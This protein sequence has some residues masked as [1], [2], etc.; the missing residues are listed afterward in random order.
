MS[1]R[2]SDGMPE[3]TAVLDRA[4][5]R[6]TLRYR[7]GS[8]RMPVDRVFTL[9]GIGTVVTGTVW[10]GTVAVGDTVAVEPGDLRARARS[11]HVHD[12][13]RE[14]ASAG[15]R[16]AVALP[17]ISR[18]HI[19]R[20]SWLVTP[21]SVTDTY[22]VECDLRVTGASS[23]DLDHGGLVTVHHGTAHVPARVLTADGESIR[24]GE[25]G[26][27]QLRLRSA[28]FAVAGDRIIV[29]LTA[30]PATVA[31]G[32]ILNPTARRT[33]QEPEAAAP[34]A[35][36][37][38]DRTGSEDELHRRIAE[39]PLAPPNL[40]AE[41][42]PLIAGLV[43]RGLAVRASRD[44]AFDAGAFWD[45]ADAVLELAADAPG[46]T[47][48]E[49]RDRLGCSRRHAQAIVEGLD[50]AGFTRRVGE[51]RVLRRRGRHQLDSR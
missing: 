4:V 40:T 31:G 35:R 20:G 29:R 37:S 28:L 41:D 9:R 45:A 18:D 42:D 19:G 24:R 5:D 1:A 26:W 14:R 46:V 50:S 51:R 22:R 21:G 10:S 16:A 12:Q 36:P 27:A 30:P 15:H 6:A 44:I 8:F 11:V 38:V 23:H 13:P 32:V 48:A 49:V 7:S 39:R 2:T 34:V 3:L 43:A 33:H 25:S 17:G 47:L